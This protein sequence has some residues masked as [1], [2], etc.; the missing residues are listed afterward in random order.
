MINYVDLCSTLTKPLILVDLAWM[1]H[2]ITS[3][4][5]VTY[6]LTSSFHSKGDS[7]NVFVLI[8]SLC[9]FASFSC[10]LNFEL[11]TLSF[12]QTL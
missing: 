7:P 4:R 11:S 3:E 12:P 8:H 2:G 10:W 1:H 5:P 6:D 9:M